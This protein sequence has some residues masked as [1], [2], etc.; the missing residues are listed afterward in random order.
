M[1]IQYS[2][3]S[4]FKVTDAASLSLPNGAWAVCFWTNVSAN[5]GS[6]AQFFVSSSGAT[7]ALEIYLNEASNASPNIWNARIVDDDGTTV[8][9]ASSSAPGGDSNDRLIVVQRNNDSNQFEMWFCTAGG[10]ASQVDT[11]VDTNMAGS[12]LGDWYVG[13]R[14][15]IADTV[16]SGN[17]TSRLTFIDN[18]YLTQ[19]QIEAIANYLL[20]RNSGFSTA[21]DID[22]RDSSSISDVH[23]NTI[24][25]TGTFT[26]GAQL[27]FGFLP[28]VGNV[29]FAGG[30]PVDSIAGSAPRDITNWWS[31]PNQ[32]WNDSWGWMGTWWKT[33]AEQSPSSASV[34]FLGDI[35]IETTGG[36][37]SQVP[38]RATM[39]FQGAEVSIKTIHHA[40]P[41]SGMISIRGQQSGA[42]SK[43]T[44]PN[45]GKIIFM[46]SVLNSVSN[47]WADATDTVSDQWVKV[48]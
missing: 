4:Y 19:T 9:L 46:G 8:F 20:P 40:I 43:T 48:R 5:T 23:G 35:P 27:P 36:E 41:S 17:Q 7:A 18:A 26:D 24:T 31:Q 3:S 32:W 38:F 45:A 12:D 14:F 39:H 25:E 47:D 29:N 10:S 6:N 21:L 13:T 30:V 1:S 44:A 34:S 42:P 15:F 2:G 22:M 28:S 37:G 33:V 16:N 11:N